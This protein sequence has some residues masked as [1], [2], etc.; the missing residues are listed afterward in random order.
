MPYGL[1]KYLKDLQFTTT[2]FFHSFSFFI[3]QVSQF[4]QERRNMLT[5]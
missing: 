2:Q 5:I 1:T 3:S 4:S